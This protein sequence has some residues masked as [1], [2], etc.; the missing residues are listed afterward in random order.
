MIK[1][2]LIFLIALIA[3]SC[4]IS[5]DTPNTYQELLPIESA[6][7]PEEFQVSVTYEIN[8]TY[9][10]PTT[11]HSFKTLYYLKNGNERTVAIIS[12]IV[13]TNDCSELNT[14]EE[15]SFDF[16][17]TELGSYVFKFWQGTDENAQDEY[18]TI[19]VPVV[20]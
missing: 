2:I 1:K 9:I 3:F 14:E 8:L 4:D 5:D 13:D 20:E 17:P 6:I 11:C 10:K 19:E 15:V 7:V 16:L 12:A 18:L